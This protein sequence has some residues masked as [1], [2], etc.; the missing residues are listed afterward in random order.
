[1]IEIRSF[2]DLLR[3]FFIFRREA[4]TAFMVTLVIVVLGAFLLPSRYEANARLL[5]KPGRDNATLPIEVSN[6]QALVAPSTQRD[7]VV[8]E[9]KLLT[10]KGIARLLA[11]DILDE[12]D[13]Y[14]PEG[15]WESFKHGLKQTAGSA[16][17][18]VRN[19][20]VFAHVLEAKPFEERLAE[21]LLKGFSV[22]HDAGSNVMELRLLWG[23]PQLAGRILE[24]WV[25]F[26]LEERTRSLGRTSLQGFY[27]QELTRQD[28]H[29]R[30]LKA[31][32]QE[33][34]KN[35]N[36]AGVR[37]R[38]E[39]LMDQTHRL[40]DLRMEKTN[41]MAGLRRLMAEAK[42]EIGNHPGEVVVERELSLNPTQL[43]LKLKLNRLQEE[44]A[45]LLRTYLEDA[46]QIKKLDE[47]IAGM[48]AL[49]A[50]ERERLERSQNRAPNSLVVGMRQEILDAGLRL[51]RLQH[52]VEDIDQQLQAIARE[53][54]A[55]L[56]VEPEITR[57]VM[58]LETAEKSYVLYSDNL[59]QA[60][61]DKALDDSLISNISIVE[62]ASASAGRIFPKTLMLL[63]LAVPFAA[64]CGLLTIYLCYL[65]DQRIHDGS[66][67]EERFGVPLWGVLPELD[68]PHQVS[69]TF[70]AGLYRIL[71][72]LSLQQIREKGASLALATTH[73]GAGVAFVVERLS[74]LLQSQGIQV[75][76]NIPPT[77]LQPGMLVLIDAGSLVE[78]PSALMVMSSAEKRLVLIQARRTT[79]P[80]L[81]NALAILSTAFGKVD[82]VVLNRRRF[83]VPASVLKRFSA[84]GSTD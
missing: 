34:Y 53:R 38:I 63:L 60:R 21:R 10:G 62:Q 36:S 4:R 76:G 28:E 35:I 51:E 24:R 26:Y 81:N 44:R 42:K 45:T 56:E 25:D 15:G 74:G 8:D 30:Q 68:S 52:E 13:A 11:R 82:G 83:E 55:V 47:S 19:A 17:E 12:L 66:K 31:E 22:S 9:E 7:P 29:I 27:E 2:R 23:D 49:V 80:M 79:V 57:L 1:M 6:R 58:Q 65:I 41:E 39:H 72:M 33:H 69:T 14:Q 5:V 77:G 78:N 84:P 67:L 50:G 40:R 71:S 20:L 75:L 73:S 54:G 3:L 48:R 32:L 70:D 43:D 64:S 18:G 59:E 61:I 16:K 37:E 46:P